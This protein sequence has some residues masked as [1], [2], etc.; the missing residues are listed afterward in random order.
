VLVVGGGVVGTEAAAVARG[1]GAEVVVLERS[2]DRIR[3]LDD[4]FGGQVRV[5]ASADD[6]LLDEAREAD[7]LVGA[8]LLPGRSAPK[9]LSRRQLGELRP[10]TLL[11]DVAIDQGGCFETSRPT[12]H[13]EPTYVEDGILHYCVANMPGAV[14]VTST[15]ALT[16]A[17]LPYILELAA[18]GDPTPR[19][20]TGVNVM[21]GRIVHHGVAE[22]FPDLPADAATAARS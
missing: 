17:T 21:R 6:A 14:P 4:R 11:V 20:A 16:Q 19:L 13:D 22:A 1:M 18:T 5:L 2:L 9:L 8:V 12:T 7:A 3:A 15:R 10:G